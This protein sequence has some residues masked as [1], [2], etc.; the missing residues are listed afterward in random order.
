MRI[1]IYPGTF[2][3]ITLGHL[4]IIK[5]AKNLVDRLIIGVAGNLHKNP[6]FSIEV[7]AQMIEEAIRVEGS[8]NIEVK[9]F[10]S[11]LV[12]FAKE[13]DAALIIRGLRAVSDFEYEFKMSW[14]NHC[15]NS[16]IETIFL[17]ASKETQFISS[18]LIKE[19]AG[20]GGAVES[21]VPLSVIKHLIN[22]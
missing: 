22:L 21:F 2:D 1:G 16:N 10:N 18:N 9:T 12:D 17:P 11:L 8:K 6:F 4:D 7:R 3:P 13:Q 20:M 15:L 19:I 14:I 5:R